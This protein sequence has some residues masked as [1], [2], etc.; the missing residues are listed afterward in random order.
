MVQVALDAQF[1]D[2]ALQTGTRGLLRGADALYVTTA[3]LNQTRL[4]SWDA[5]LLQRAEAITPSGWLAA[6]P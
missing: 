6:N 1:L 2:Q 5:E 4:V 3:E